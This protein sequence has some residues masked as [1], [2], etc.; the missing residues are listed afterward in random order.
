MIIG[1]QSFLAS[2][3]FCMSECFVYL[4]YCMKM[5]SS[6][7]GAAVSADAK[8]LLQDVQVLWALHCSY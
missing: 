1:I 8:C 7:P 5:Q 4:Q 6:A 3:A 2:A